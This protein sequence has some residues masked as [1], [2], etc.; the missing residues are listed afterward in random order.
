MVRVPVPCDPLLGEVGLRR[1]ANR[2]RQVEFPK[3]RREPVGRALI[4]WLG[5]NGGEMSGL[6]KLLPSNERVRGFLSFSQWD[7]LIAFLRSGW[8][9]SA[10]MRAMRFPQSET[11]LSICNSV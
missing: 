11:M 7:S 5:A 3:M 2:W 9:G 8:R 6:G 1:L 4:A 10:E